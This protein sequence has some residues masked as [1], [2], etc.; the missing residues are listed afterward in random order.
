MKNKILYLFISFTLLLSMPS[1]L[2]EDLG[3]YDYKEINEVVVT[4]IETGKYIT[5]IAFIDTYD[6]KPEISFT[7][8][9]D[10]SNYTYKWEA[11]KK[12]TLTGE[13]KKFDLG[14]EKELT[15]IV[16]LPSG[17]YVCY[18]YVTDKSTGIVWETKF[19]MMVS[20]NLDKGWAVLC[21][22][23][24]V[25]RLDMVSPITKGDFTLGG[26]VVA[27]N[28]VPDMEVMGKP[29]KL[30]IASDFH[31]D[32][33]LFYATGD[34]GT[35]R[36][37]NKS[38][39]MGDSTDL[40]LEYGSFPDKVLL[41]GMAQTITND[42]GANWVRIAVDTEG[43]FKLKHY[44]VSGSI[45]MMDQNLNPT[46]TPTNGEQRYFTAAP[47]CG[48]R[49]IFYPMGSMANT[50]EPGGGQN[51]NLIV[52]DQTYKRF[53]RI[54]NTANKPEVMSF[55]NDGALWEGAKTGLRMIYGENISISGNQFRQMFL[56]LLTDETDVWLYAVAPL[57]NGGNQQMYFK[58]LAPGHDLLNA[59]SYAF[60]SARERMYFSKGSSVYAIDYSSQGD[61]TAQEILNYPGEEVVKLCFW[62]RLTNVIPLQQPWNA[63]TDWL[64]VGSNKIGAD[65]EHSGTLRSYELPSLMGGTHTKKVE[66]DDLGKIVDIAFKEIMATKI[67]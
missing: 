22:V 65:D 48:V 14:E 37:K 49:L 44:D 5:K 13:K 20:S 21:D 50:G 58:K 60:S 41:A 26:W 25:G 23:N 6:L 54:A 45:Y 62:L 36:I 3:N 52:Y 11:L 29:R 53:L 1:C 67:N 59:T 38:F 7:S 12:G 19:Y 27:R 17:E 35:Y 57:K 43:N 24:G 33:S 47:W 16:E 56:T 42:K 31:T 10:A 55:T 46:Y 64:T 9:K 32:H 51:H 34:Q 15:S 66:E 40:R 63:S 30:F 39:N 8:N 28:T 4:G 18:F 2:Y 61:G